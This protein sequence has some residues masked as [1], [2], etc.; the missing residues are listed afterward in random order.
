VVLEFLQLRPDAKGNN[1]D[2]V[3]LG[4]RLAERKMS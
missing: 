4:G 2:L 1:R 3:R